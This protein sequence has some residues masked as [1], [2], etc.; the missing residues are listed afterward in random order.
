MDPEFE[1]LIGLLKAAEERAQTASDLTGKF[2][3]EVN[4]AANV[5]VVRRVT[6]QFQEQIGAAQQEVRKAVAEATELAAKLRETK[7]TEPVPPSG[8]SVRAQDI[9]AHFRTLV[10]TVQL[11][12][13]QPRA[14]ELAT[15]LKSFDVELKGLIVVQDKEAHVITPSP[16]RAVDPGQLSTIR[17]SFASVPVLRPAEPVTPEP[18][19]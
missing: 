17:M 14:G 9:A 10:D 18:P 7:P 11:E 12:A 13:R 6:K 2:I 5:D 4:N 19:R 16:D 15:T 8:P 1:R 3:A